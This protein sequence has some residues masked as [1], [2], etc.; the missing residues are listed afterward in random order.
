M[1]FNFWYF[2]FEGLNRS[3]SCFPQKMLEKGRL[4]I[5]CETFPHLKI[6]MY[7]DSLQ[8]S[9]IIIIIIIIVENSRRAQRT[10]DETGE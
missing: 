10:R 3:F 5:H 6:G 8:N 4:K 2:L 7:S 9:R 1:Q